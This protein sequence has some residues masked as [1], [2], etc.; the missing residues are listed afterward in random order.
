MALAHY[1][2]ARTTLDIDI[3]VE[4]GSGNVRKIVEA[5]HPDY[6]IAE[7]SVRHAIEHKRMFN[8]LE[9]KTIIKV[10]CVIRKDDAY[11]KLAFSRRKKVEYVTSVHIWIATKEDL[12]LSK[13]KWAKNTHSEMQIRDVS[14]LV[15]NGYDEE[16]VN[17]WAARLEV[18]EL[19]KEA[20]EKISD[21]Y[22][23]G[24]DA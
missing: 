21:Q 11:S 22:A 13:L 3:V 20:S 7:E 10:D 9:Q 2:I 19:L 17:G 23:E 16:Y 4:I 8:I 24:Y 12:I 5:F 18:E 1:A 15:R 14:S 6:Y